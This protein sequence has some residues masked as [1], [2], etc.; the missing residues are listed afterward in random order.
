MKGLYVASIVAY[1]SKGELN[2][3]AQLKLMDRNLKEGAVGFFVGGSSGECFLISPEE[4]VKSYEVAGEY[5]SK[6]DLFAHVGALS[7][8]E[9]IYYAKK[10]KELGYKKLAATPPFYFGYSQEAIAKYYQDISEAVDLPVLYYNIPMNTHKDLILTDPA[11][12]KL[13]KSGVLSGIKHTHF[14]INQCER[15]QNINPELQMYGG[16]E[17][18]MVAFMA[19]GCESFIGSTF[20]FMTP[21][22]KKIYDLYKQGNREEA[23]KLQ[24][25]ANNIM[26]TIWNIGLFPAIKH[27]LK[28]QGNDVGEVR[29]PFLPLTEEQKATIDQVVQENIYQGD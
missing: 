13:L 11:T 18:N 22:Y 10:A 26:E 16:L 2:A 8:D 21:H 7:T 4:R 15:I 27:I 17:Q 23:L 1:D 12:Q 20:N 19:L 5:L 3:D 25:K 9:A 28:T 24:V 6:A 29:R 14:D